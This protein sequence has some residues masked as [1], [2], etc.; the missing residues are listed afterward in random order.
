MPNKETHRAFNQLLNT[1]LEINNKEEELAQDGTSSIKLVPIF[2]YNDTDKKL[3]VEFKIGNEQLTKINN[4]PDFFERMLNREKYKYNNVLEFIH[5]ENAFEEQSRPLLKF[6][7]KYAEIIKYA[8]DVNNNYAYYGRNFNVNNVVLSNTGLD[9]LFEIL[10]GKTVEFETKTG[11]R[12]IQFI[13][14]PIDIKFIL[15]K[16]DESTY[17]LTPNIDVYGYDIFYG[18]NYSYFL[19]DNKMHKCLPKVENRNLELLEVYKKNYT[20]SIVFNENNLRNFFAIVVPKIKDNFEI[21]NI[22]KEQ[23]EKYMPK[24]LY[25]KIYLDYNEKGYIIADIKFCYGNVEF[26]PI[27]NVNLEITRNAIQEN[28]VLDT[29]VQTGFMLDSANARLVLAND[30]KIYN[31]L[32]KEI[33]DYMK[34]FEVL[35]AEDFK[36]KDIKKIKIKSIG[37]KIENNLLDINLGDFKFNIYEIK[38]IINKYKLRKKFYRLK[39][40]TYISLEKNSSLDFLENLTDNIEI[41]D[42]NV[43]E[44]SIKLPIYRALYLEKIF[45]NMPNTNIQKNEYYKNMISQIEDRQI[46]LSTKIPPKLN[47][48]L[49]TYQKIGYKWLRTLEQYK[50]GGILAD[51][52]GLGKTIQLLAVILS[53]VQKNKENVKPSIII[54]PSSLALNWYNEIQKFTPTL[55]ALVISDDYLERKRKIEEIGKYQVIIT[56]YDSLKR[57]IDLYENYCFKYVVADEAQ[58]IK[59]NNTKNSKAI[60]TINAETKF[61]LT[62]TPIENSLSELWS[63]FDFI[64]PGYLYKYKKFKELYETP[65]I[66]EQNEDVMNKLKK[67][68]EPFVLRRTKGEVLTELPDKT[69]TILNNEMSEEQYNIYMSYMAQARKEIM[70]QIDINGFEKSQIKILSL[71]MRLRQIC[72]HPKLF[73][74]EYEGESS[75]LNQC[76]EIIQDAVLGGHKILLFSSYTSMFEIIEEKLKNIGVKYLKLTGQT[77]VGE[78]IEL[79]D[80]F[81]TDENIKVF[82]ISLKAGGTGLNLTGADMVIHY[83]PWWNLSAENQATDRTYRI[84]QKRNVQVYKLITKNSIEEKIYELQQKKAK[85]IDNM[86]STD[87]TFIN[88]LSKDDIL[89]LFE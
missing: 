88:K 2:L 85:L 10:K 15:E 1:F 62:G 83:D 16:S 35:V 57:D 58:Y 75:K 81:N 84:G 41:E 4:L 72:C 26:N 5:E 14:E 50:M 44:N 12:K 47:A 54:C 6:L 74:G 73:L 59:N 31:F 63:I 87:A 38:D 65:I 28:E 21:K 70:S 18:K 27:K 79:V 82:L 56:S 64:M 29:F 55:K 36:K 67:Q 11:E 48:E 60:K 49:R 80:K 78:R 68:I 34:K 89:A 32:S 66:K 30:E 19:I 23:I 22:D 7:L 33:E 86:L 52:M 25:V 40:G 51:D 76:I 17:C 45:K 37:V 61:A 13:D 46:D 53:Y 43:E 39:D 20:Q 77:K 8:N 3:K 42:E 69:V 71:L 24:D 9:E